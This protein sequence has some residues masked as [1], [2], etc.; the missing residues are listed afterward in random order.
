MNRRSQTLCFRARAG[1]LVLLIAWSLV[2]VGCAKN[3][4]ANESTPNSNGSPMAADAAATAP[5]ND[6]MAKLPI[7]PGATHAASTRPDPGVAQISS[8]LYETHDSFDKVY[9]W[10]QSRLPAHSETSQEHSQ[11]EDLALFTL[12]AGKDHQSVSI[13]K[14]GGVEV[15]N[16]T[17]TTTKIIK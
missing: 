1:M 12:T 2:T 10:Y 14:T 6:L 4:S 3:D 15:T 9:K 11:N 5:T 7:Y 16:I 13:L 8:D 17:L